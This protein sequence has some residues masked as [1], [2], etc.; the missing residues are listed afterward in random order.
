MAMTV[1]E[2]IRKRI[3]VRKFRPDPVPEALVREILELARWSPSGGN[4]QPWHVYVMAGPAL[5]RFK[6]LIAGRMAATPMGDGS[7]FEIYPANLAEPYRTRRF[8]IGEAMYEK[9]GIPR[10]DKLARLQHLARN[11]VFF[12]APVGL[13]FAIDKSMGLP[14]WAH[15]GMFMQTLMLAAEERG[16]G[17]CAQEAWSR[18]PNAIREFVAMP[19]A[20]RLYCGMA[21]GFVD[22]S[23]PVN[24]LRSARASVAEF[25]TFLSD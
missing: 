20:L 10:E 4:V 3:S 2:A 9:L 17:T 15:L 22:E 11:F 25:A 18:W 13:F 6:A 12:D 19:D 1:G 16:L 5:A 24:T 8:A 14:Q 7:E 21:L 23:A